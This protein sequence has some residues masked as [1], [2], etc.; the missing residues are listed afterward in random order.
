[1][2]PRHKKRIEIVQN[3]YAHGFL[4][5]EKGLPFPLDKTTKLIINQSLSIDRLIETNAPRFSLDKIA[6]ID[7]AILRL[8]IYELTIEKKQPQKV[9]INEAV[10]LAK[11]LGGE[12]SFSFVNAVLG[13]IAITTKI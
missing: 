1:M 13:K 8:A 4:L 6:K 3:L 5:K 10:E 12:K 11:E 9:I 2:D 7:L